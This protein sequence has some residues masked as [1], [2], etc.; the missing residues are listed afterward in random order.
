MSKVAMYKGKTFFHISLQNENE[1]HT[2]NSLMVYS[3]RVGT[4]KFARL[5]I[6][7]PVLDKIGQSIGT[8]LV[9]RLNL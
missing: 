6:L 7:L 3:L 1:S 4:R 9:I 5:Y 8:F 2:F